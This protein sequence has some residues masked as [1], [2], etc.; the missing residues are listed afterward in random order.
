MVVTAN[1]SKSQDEIIIYN[2][3]RYGAA[4]RF[5]H[6]VHAA[7]MALFI[8]TGWQIHT[9]EIIIGDMAQVRTVHIMLGIFI[10]LW[11]LICNPLL[12]AIDGHLKDI[13][14]TPG[15]VRDLIFMM[16]CA[17]NILD[18][19]YYPHYDF[20]DP[21]LG[22]YIR[23]YHPGQ[24]FLAI[25]DLVAMLLMGSTGIALAET[26][27]PG[28]TGIMAFLA[29]LNVIVLPILDILGMSVRFF[30]FLLFVFFTLTTLFHVYFAFIP[31]NVS[32]LKAM[33]T[34]KEDV[35]GEVDH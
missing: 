18:D 25:S 29:G 35:S 30:H 22:V 6:W 23:K 16:L 34:G 9:R 31:Q 24:K 27:A 1:E 3:R 5:Y 13:I 15:D 12:L 26:Q 14:P 2:V 4:G 33:I 32:R 17:L 28:S 21:E 7:S 19:S 11:D 8:S 10:L 20:Y